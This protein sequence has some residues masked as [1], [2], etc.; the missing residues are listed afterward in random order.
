MDNV[1]GFSGF[2]CREIN[3]N[4]ILALPENSVLLK[5]D[6]QKSML[7]VSCNFLIELLL[8]LCHMVNKV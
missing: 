6:T 2:L 7:H 8:K 3:D 1:L 5:K 4:R